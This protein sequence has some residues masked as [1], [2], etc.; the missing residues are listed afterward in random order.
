MNGARELCFTSA[1]RSM[2]QPGAVEKLY[3]CLIAAADNVRLFSG[4][5]GRYKLCFT[6]ELGQAFCESPVRRRYQYHRRRQLYGGAIRLGEAPAPGVCCAS[7]RSEGRL[8]MIAIRSACAM[9]AALAL[10]LAMA[11]TAQAQC[12]G[13][14][15]YHVDVNTGPPPGDDNQ[16]SASP[17]SLSQQG[18][19]NGNQE[20]AFGNA[21]FGSVG[22]KTS[23]DAVAC[24]TNCN[25]LVQ[26][27]ASADYIDYFDL[28]L[29]PGLTDGQMLSFSLSLNGSFG[30]GFGGLAM[31]GACI[32]FINDNNLGSVCLLGDSI[33]PPTG[34]ATMSMPVYPSLDE[35]GYLDLEIVTGTSLEFS[36]SGPGS[37]FA[38]FSDT[39][40]I[41]NVALLD[42]DGNFLRNIVLTDTAGFTL[43]GPGP[44]G[45]APEPPTLLLVASALAVLGTLSRRT[46]A[47]MSN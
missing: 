23:V 44:G 18:T 21:Q 47:A 9:V 43:P 30:V 20:Q 16:F 38:D 8:L 22:S 39:F 3:I 34:T 14:P 25:E 17:F 37:G 40:S 28:L 26:A 12:P 35:F 42:A 6:S 4:L 13:N 7:G 5:N 19:N 15:C 32:A 36:Q 24:P 1:E 45:T 31:V 11:A 41:T 27:N 2:R 29:T 10:T 33:S 46:R